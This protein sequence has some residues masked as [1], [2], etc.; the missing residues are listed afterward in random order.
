MEKIQISQLFLFT[1]MFLVFIFGYAFGAIN[2]NDKG[3]VAQKKREYKDPG[4]LPHEP[5]NMWIGEPGKN[6]KYCIMLPIERDDDDYSGAGGLNKCFG[7]D[8]RE[9]ALEAYLMHQ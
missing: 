8:T 9:D 5:D 4:K 1:L 2:G 6:G 3:K 7:Y